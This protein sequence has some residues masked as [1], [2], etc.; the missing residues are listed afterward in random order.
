L[1]IFSRFVCTYLN[2]DAKN[3]L[4]KLKKFI[5][6]YIYPCNLMIV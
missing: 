6:I 4:M 2:A 3:S 1:T 5:F